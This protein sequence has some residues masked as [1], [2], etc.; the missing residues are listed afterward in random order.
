MALTTQQI[1]RYSR[2]II[3][4]SMG[5]RAQ[6][7]LL[8]SRIVLAGDGAELESALSYLVGAGVGRIELAAESESAEQLTASMRSLNP[9]VTVGAVDRDSKV[10]DLG[11]AI[12]SG[13]VAYEAATGAIGR[14]PRIG[15]VIARL[16]EPARIAVL[17]SPPPCPRCAGGE[18]LSP[19]KRRA[20]HA[21]VVALA[22]TVEVLKLLAG[23][24]KNPQPA[25]IEF[26]GYVSRSR[27]IALDSACDCGRRGA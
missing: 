24:A 7:R 13:N 8:Q 16:D 11:V 23:Y 10:P 3:V 6:E 14:F 9:D 18:L 25:M 19:F 1:E 15:W 26:E 5:G 22:A 17:P 21:R 12:V 4:P 27:R 20:G 2:Q